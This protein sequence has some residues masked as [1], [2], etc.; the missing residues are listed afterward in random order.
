MF[1]I[2]KVIRGGDGVIFSYTNLAQPWPLS[3]VLLCLS[4]LLLKL[5]KASGNRIQ[6]NRLRCGNLDLALYSH[7]CFFSLERAMI[8]NLN[9]TECSLGAVVCSEY[10]T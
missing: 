2:H 10:C 5:L 3:H 4:P 6:V 8:L 9:N 7:M 1:E